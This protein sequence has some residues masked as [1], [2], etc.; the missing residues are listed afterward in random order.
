M[1]VAATFHESTTDLKPEGVPL[2]HL[3]VELGHLYMDD[4]NGGPDRLDRHFRQIAP[5]IAA[6]RTELADQLPPGTSPRISTCF[7]IDD[8]FTRFST[9]AVV[10]PQLLEAAARH[11]LAIDYIARESACAESGGAPVAAIV[12]SALVPDPPQQTTGTRPPATENG[13]LS[14]GQRSPGSRPRAAMEKLTPWAP[15]MENGRNRH[16]IFVDVEIWDERDG[17]RTWS[18]PF[19][20]AVWQLLRLGML[21]DLGKA[22][23]QPSPLDG[24][25]PAEWDA[26]PAITQVNNR[27]KP[28]S[29]YGTVSVLAPRFLAIEHA[30]GTILSQV[31]VDP[32]VHAQVAARAEAEGISLAAQAVDRIG[33][34]FPR[35]A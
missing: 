34:I 21:R 3:S 20:A 1:N 16:S 24:E 32:R 19:L 12:E 7:L 15:P 17:K 25:W 35:T 27:A 28:F 23:G 6:V 2:A 33:Y 26:L 30:V 31:A 13:W 4:Y 9:P 22:V 10:I 8:Y 11:S 29:A 18:C 5:W 14:N